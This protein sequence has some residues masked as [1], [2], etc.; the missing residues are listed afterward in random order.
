MHFPDNVCSEIIRLSVPKAIKHHFRIKE[1]QKSWVLWVRIGY[2]T[3]TKLGFMG[4]GWVLGNIPNTYP[5]TQ[6]SLGYYV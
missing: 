2:E 5:K 6:L 4:L 1:T 3:Q